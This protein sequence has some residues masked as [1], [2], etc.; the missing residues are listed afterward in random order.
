MKMNGKL[1]QMRKLLEVE[2]IWLEIVTIITKTVIAKDEREEQVVLGAIITT[3]NCFS[4]EII[5]INV[6]ILLG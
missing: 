3:G 2:S 4:Q 5:T 6:M 1:L